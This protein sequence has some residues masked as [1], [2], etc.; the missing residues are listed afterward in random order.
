[1][2]SASAL[3]RYAEEFT[4]WIRQKIEARDQNALMQTMALA[5]HAKRA[6]PTTEHLLPLF[7]AM[8]AASDL[9]KVSTLQ[10]GITHGVLSM[11]SYVFGW[12][13][14]EVQA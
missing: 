6:H 12:D 2:A 4:N 11:E 7:I 13:A 9:A 14:S 10:G 8:G 3:P 5:P 1:V